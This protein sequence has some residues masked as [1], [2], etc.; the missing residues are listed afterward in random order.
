MANYFALLCLLCCSLTLQ[1][2][3]PM[4]IVSLTPHLTELLFLVGAGDH[5]VPT[6]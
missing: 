5:N 4:R 3:T 1:A 6:S 2:A